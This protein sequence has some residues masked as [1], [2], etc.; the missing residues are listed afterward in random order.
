MSMSF[1]GEHPITISSDDLMRQAQMT[2]HDYML[3]ASTDI[4]R[5]FGEGVA[6]KH[7]ELVAAYIQTAALD[8]GAA[9]YCP[10][11]TSRSRRHRRSDSSRREPKCGGIK[12]LLGLF[13][14]ELVV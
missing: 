11:N 3:G 6:R 10:A 13:G 2:A 5:V 14:R 9:I 7:P 12:N 1:A 8:F 4:D